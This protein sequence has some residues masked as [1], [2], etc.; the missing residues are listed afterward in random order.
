MS[1]TSSTRGSDVVRAHDLKVG[2]YTIPTQSPES[3]GTLEWNSTTL[4][5]VAIDGA[6][7][8]GI[9]YTYASSAAA[10]IINEILKPVVV[11]GNIMDI[12]LLHNEMIKAVRN[13]GSGLTMMAIS[14]VD[15]A[16]WDLKSKLLDV[17]LSVLLGKVKEKM[18]VYGSGGFTSYNKSQLQLQAKDWVDRGI[19]HVKIK[20]G[21]EPLKDVERVT[22]VREAIGEHTK[23]FVDANGAYTV[24]QAIEKAWEFTEFKVIWFEEP[25]AAYNHEG[26]RFIREQVP[27]MMNITGGEYGDSLSYFE[28][29]LQN[30]TVDILQADVTRCG[31][32]TGFLK[33]GVLAEV[34]GLPFS[35]HCAPSLHI[36]PAL[37]LPSFFI[38]EYFFDHVRIESTLFDGFIQPINGFIQPDLSRPGLGIEFKYDDAERYRN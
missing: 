27:P 26:L 33:A 7:E 3:D 19:S 23:L 35:S 11:G 10:N 18:M 34:F 31:G 15:I 5:L 29:M 21:R 1:V 4:V 36:A 6:G 12:P 38:A 9:G 17:P 22:Q 32:I 14:A 25:I 30:K 16:L 8:T 13:Q 20:V 37:A 2:S 24:K 28:Q